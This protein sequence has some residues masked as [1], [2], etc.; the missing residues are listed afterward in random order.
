METAERAKG[1]RR[2]DAL[3][4]D[5]PSLCDVLLGTTADAAPAAIVETGAVATGVAAATIEASEPVPLPDTA[6][7]VTP[8]EQDETL[9][10]AT[11]AESD[12]MPHEAQTQEPQAQEAQ[13][14]DAGLN[15]GLDELDS[16][17]A[18]SEVA[19]PEV[20]T[21]EVAAPEAITPEVAAVLPDGT[22]LARETAPAS[23]DTAPFSVEAETVASD[24]GDDWTFADFDLDAPPAQAPAAPAADASGADDDPFAD[25]LKPLD[26]PAP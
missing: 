2:P 24:T 22:A 14:Q 19:A 4:H 11:A 5:L 3:F 15:W 9:V 17:P 21:P 1:E 23:V 12:A 8:L 6:E 20:I 7:A 26:D 25:W 16:P 10:A 18:A 13:T